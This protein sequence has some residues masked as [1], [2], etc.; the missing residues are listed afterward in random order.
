MA[1]SAVMARGSKVEKAG[2][3]GLNPNPPGPQPWLFPHPLCQLTAQKI[4]AGASETEIFRD[5]VLVGK[6]EKGVLIASLKNVNGSRIVQTSLGKT[7]RTLSGP[8]AHLQRRS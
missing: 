8:S 7:Q 1:A 6:W 3:G 5:K 2:W 4:E